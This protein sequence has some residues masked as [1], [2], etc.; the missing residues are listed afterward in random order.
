MIIKYEA[1]FYKKAQKTV[2]YV[3]TGIQLFMKSHGGL[4]F[5]CPVW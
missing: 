3:S 5:Y 2:I 1:M 4:E